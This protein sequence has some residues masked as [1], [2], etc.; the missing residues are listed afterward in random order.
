[1]PEIED[2]RA[3]RMRLIL[4]LRQAG[5]REPR[6][7]AVLEQVP[8]D[9]FLPGELPEDVWEDIALPLPGGEVATR[10]SVI[11]AALA[12]LAPDSHSLVLEIGTGSGYQAALLTQMARKVISLERRRGLA[13]AARER[14]GKLRLLSAQVHCADGAEGW[15]REAPFDRIILNAAAPSLDL[16]RTQLAPRGVLVA[17]LQKPQGQVLARLTAEGVYEELPLPPGGEFQPLGRG[18]EEDL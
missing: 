15:A 11:G 4:A 5:L 10:P 9:W 8:R 2:P 12:L 14:L 13:V 1:M 3:L 17:P 7:L 6:V 16:W 18:L